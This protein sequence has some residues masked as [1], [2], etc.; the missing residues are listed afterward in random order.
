VR[1][2]RARP[3]CRHG[4]GGVVVTSGA[5]HFALGLVGDSDDELS[6]R[7]WDALGIAMAEHPSA[8]EQTLLTHAL[9]DLPPV[10]RNQR[11][12]MLGRRRLILDADDAAMIHRAW[13]Q[14]R[15]ISPA[16]VRGRR[17]R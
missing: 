17:T 15:M 11:P 1:L 12:A 13:R 6:R 16:Q 2:F 14:R 3:R 7:L 10:L 9:A 8:D 4:R 5:Y